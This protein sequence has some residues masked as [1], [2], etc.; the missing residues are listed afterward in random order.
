MHNHLSNMGTLYTFISFLFLLMPLHVKEQ[1]CVTV[2]YV[3][4]QQQT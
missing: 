1:M 3:K 2:L 4:N